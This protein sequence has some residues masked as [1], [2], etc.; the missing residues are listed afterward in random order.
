MNL[1]YA[2]VLLILFI[3]LITG[4]VKGQSYCVEPKVDWQQ[5]DTHEI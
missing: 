2:T 4:M 3:F 5:I 1:S